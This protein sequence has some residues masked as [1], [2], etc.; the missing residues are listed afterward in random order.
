[1]RLWNNQQILQ[2][3]LWRAFLSLSQTFNFS[4]LHISC[5]ECC[6]KIFMKQPDKIFH[7]KVFRTH[8]IAWPQLNLLVIAIRETADRGKQF[9]CRFDLFLERECFYLLSRDESRVWKGPRLRIPC[10]RRK[11]PAK[12]KV[13]SEREIHL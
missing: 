7:I 4:N 6:V 1:M 10:H 2:S 12:L 8:I 5:D 3:L 9:V 11:H 13:S